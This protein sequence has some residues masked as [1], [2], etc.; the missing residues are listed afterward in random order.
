[1][2][3]KEAAE[4]L[5]ST[6]KHHPGRH[7]RITEISVTYTKDGRVVD[8]ETFEVQTRSKSYAR[9]VARMASLRASRESIG[10]SA[11]TTATIAAFGGYRNIGG[12]IYDVSET[13][14]TIN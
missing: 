10:E 14:G 6:F 4:K 11:R 2:D 13:I 12:G 8:I 7:E 3:S 5:Y 9:H 1:M